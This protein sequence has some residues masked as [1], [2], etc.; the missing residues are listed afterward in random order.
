[1]S[2]RETPITGLLV[3]QDFGRAAA[4]RSRACPAALAPTVRGAP[5]ATAPPGA[6]AKSIAIEIP[7]IAICLTIFML[8]S[9]LSL[10]RLAVCLAILLLKWPLIVDHARRVH[11]TSA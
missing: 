3:L 4:P 6:T 7:L 2:G 1:M 11:T 9:N 5:F 10:P 8:T